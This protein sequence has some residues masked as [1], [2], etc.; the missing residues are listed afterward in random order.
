MNKSFLLFKTLY[1]NS[2]EPIKREDGKKRLPSSIVA[3]LST[4]PLVIIVGAM[5]C[6][7]ATALKSDY[8]LALFVNA[9]MFT[10]Q[11]LTLFLTVSSTITTLYD[12]K[13]MPFLQTLPIK[14]TG[15]F[16][17]KF[18]LV[19]VNSLAFSSAIFLPIAY[20]V[21]ITFNVVGESVFYG[22]YAFLLLDAL[23][24][25]I[26]PT[27]LVTLFSM[28]IA[29]LGS[30]SRGKPEIKSVFTI[31]FYVLLMCAYLVLVY[32]M[33]TSA[34][35]QTGDDAI[36][37][38][39]LTSLNTLASVI[40]PD[41]VV[42]LF[43]FGIDFGKNF[44]ISCAINLSMIAISVLLS[45]LFY[46][47]ISV[48][49][50]ENAQSDVSKS[51]SL[52]QSNVVI[53]LAQRDF[54]CIMRNS[55]VAMSCFANLI[56]APLC[57]VLMYFITRFKTESGTDGGLTDVMSQMMGIGFVIMYSMIFLGGAN[58]LGAQAYTREGKS[59]FATK[60]L[61]IKPSDS[62]KSKL[63]L[64]TIVPAV[65]MIPIML[66]S[67]ILYKIDIASTI[68]IGIDTMLTVVGVNSFNILFDMKKGNQHWDDVAEL[69]N[70]TKNNAYQV[71]GAFMAVV[72]AIILF[73]I[74]M[75]L[76]S[77]CFGLGVIAIKAIYWAVATLLSGAVCLVGVLLLKRYGIEYY[78]LIGLN[79]P[80]K[81]Q[82][83][84]KIKR[85]LTK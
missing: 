67:L 49:R 27:F 55:T 63:L 84:I 72:P 61:P 4:L 78:P 62:I 7:V 22:A 56:M 77:F 35:G 76:S 39:S 38:R 59:F 12:G 17:A 33:N 71:I 13:D 9:I 21:T 10:V 23:L 70:A 37:Q 69:K 47:R 52:K 25:P 65:I 40:Y 75:L 83:K 11:I 5:L 31:V 19:Y 20:A 50:R 57:I 68:L 2:H 3:M 34:F 66:I 16:F 28:P 53:S 82:N 26:L 41:K 60:T 44:G 32:F 6:Y 46:R 51:F 74:G 58:I 30:S 54:K 18:A 24:L 80:N 8:Q 79:N 64:A 42:A 81:A 85:G 48:K 15:I 29:Y 73:V 36:S 1:K 14:S 45:S 43:T